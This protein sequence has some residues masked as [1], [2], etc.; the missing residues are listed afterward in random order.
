VKKELISQYRAALSMLRNVIVYCPESLWDCKDDG[1]SFWQL[2]Y[3]SLYFTDF[4]LADNSHRFIHWSRHRQDFQKLGRL[5]ADRT[6]MVDEIYTKTDLQSYAG[7]IEQL[8]E[9][10]VKEKSFDGPSGFEWLAMNKLESHLYNLRHLQHHTG[11]L[12]ERL[13]QRGV[14]G[15]PW[16]MQLNEHE[17]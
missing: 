9:N 4:Y 11:Q 15:I 2:V 12:V 13:H 14:N 10:Q 7:E 3:H 17:P 16:I 5:P 8:L 6:Q 1:I